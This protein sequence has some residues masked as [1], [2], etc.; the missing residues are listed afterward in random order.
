MI[1]RIHGAGGGGGQSQPKV[2]QP[3]KPVIAQDDAA[4]KSI[5]FAKLQFL[6]CEGDL[7]GPAYG[8]TKQGL[9][10]SVYL[11]DTPI[12]LSSGK[13]SPKPEDLVFS[14]GRPASEQ[15]SVPDYNELVDTIGVNQLCEF[16]KTVT[17][18]VTEFE[19]P[20][21][22]SALVLV[23]FEALQITTIDG[24]EA[25]GNTGDVRTYKVEYKVDYIDA[26][27]TKRTPYNTSVKGKFSSTFQRSHE[28]AL[29]GVGPWTVRVTRLTKDDDSYDPNEEVARSAFNFSSV[30][31][32]FKEAINYE[33]SSVLTVGVRADNYEQIPNISIEL[34]G[35]KVE[36]PKNATVEADGSLS[37]TGTW[38]GTFQTAWTSDP[39]WC[40]RDLILNERYGAGEYIDENFVD[41]WSLYQI[42]QYCNEPVPKSGQSVRLDDYSDF[43]AGS[44]ATI[45]AET[46]EN[47]KVGD[48]V[49]FMEAGGANLDSALSTGTDYVV[50]VQTSTTVQ[51]ELASAP[52]TPITLAGD[53]GTGSANTPAPAAIVMGVVEPRFSCNLLLQSSGEA[54]TVLQQVSSIFRGMVYYASSIAVVA[55]DKEK[56]AIFTFNESN[57]IEEYDDSGQVSQGN[58]TYSGS[59][60][61]A[62]RTVCLVSW[63]DPNN[64]WEPRIECVADSEALKEYGYRSVDLRVLGVTSRSQALRA[65]NWTLLSEQLLT[66]TITFKTNEIGMA[67]RP[68]DI[69]KIA[70]PT[71]AAVRAG[72]RITAVQGDKISLDYLPPNPPGGLIGSKISWMYNLPDAGLDGPNQPRLQESTVIGQF[73]P[74]TSDWENALANCVTAPDPAGDYDI[75][76][77]G[78]IDAGVFVSIC[79]D[80]QDPIFDA[81]TANWDNAD[82]QPRDEIGS[83]GNNTIIIDTDGGHPPEV[84]NPFLLEFP[85]RSAQKFR[86]LTISQEEEGVFAI[87][88]LRYRDDIYDRVD[89]DTPLDEDDD[90]LFKPVNPTE[91]TDVRA[92]VIWDNGQAKI[93]IRWT[94]PTLSS[95]LFQYNLEV[96]NY[97]VQWQS[98]TIEAGEVTW[99]GAWIELPPQTDDREMV[100]IDE[101]SISDKF[102][103]RICSV[104]RLGVQSPW[105]DYVTAEDINV[106]SPMPDISN[107]PDPSVPSTFLTYQN[108][109]TGGQLFTWNFSSV[110]VPKY[111]TGVRLDV[112][113]DT[114]LTPEQAAG[115]K[116][117]DADGYYVY[118]DYPLEEYAVAIFHADT[119]W[120]C[121]IKFLTAVIGLTGDT[122]ASVIVKRCDIVPPSPNL[123][124]VVTET[125]NKSIAPLR[126]FS[127]ELPTSEIV[128]GVGPDP[129]TCGV[130]CLCFW[131]LGKVTDISQFRI[132]YKAGVINNWDLGVPLFADG[133]PG[134]QRYFETELFDGGQWTVM[135]RS[136][137]KTGWVSDDQATIQINI[138][139]AI[140]T[141]VVDTFEAHT[142]GWPGQKTNC[143]VV[144]G[145]LVQTDPTIDA[146]YSYAFEVVTATEDSG[147]VIT[148]KSAGTYQW[149]IREVE[150]SID[151][152]MY[153]DPQGDPM[154]PDPQTDYMYLDTDNT[155]G[156]SYHPYVPFEKLPAGNYEIACVIKSVDGTTPTELE[157]ATLALD[158]PD[159]RQSMEDVAIDNTGNQTVAFPTPFPHKCKAVSITLQD[160]AGAVTVPATAY[161]RGKTVDN[162]TIRL[163][164]AD[165][166]IIEG[167]ADIVAVG[168]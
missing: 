133:V 136:V 47:F 56:D 87:T 6:L 52:G 148:T 166:N 97:R 108:Q 162:F 115:I 19:G 39:A 104:G 95:T 25:K 16:N 49:Q 164:D 5:S 160:P 124:T 98:G 70:D 21:K 2:K 159:V 79:T 35:L 117:P 135:I 138:G 157:E 141:N 121:R 167:L 9:E 67:L 107:D 86:I 20:G 50:T 161:I 125:D 137:D 30:G 163:L 126:R 85:S 146:L 26:I 101:L 106:S 17:Q 119:N 139:D 120:T 36:I 132:R 131:P 168:Y 75:S 18:T 28:F 152:P 153:P 78:T 13:I 83:G 12:R 102:R 91:P 77:A 27:G 118:G 88:G 158:Y 105:S 41:K 151:K 48:T 145:K 73:N 54:W 46:T 37:Y 24:D 40:L 64:N 76:D 143:S 34:K 111:V 122:H 156:T 7:E 89:F 51:V 130:D 129:A 112:K 61:R 59:A 4:L 11:D 94:P 72:G 142:D 45:T 109:S 22:Y 123:F 114:P 96:K 71:K 103:V 65:A 60:R 29:K 127:W 100:P 84:N 140:P 23:T 55:Q 62:R 1:K 57:T 99:S 74:G 90:S 66:D 116:P 31:V 43:P 165:G 38:D 32:A 14:Y 63:D 93:E 33:N 44:P 58:F 10:K 69:V 128:P 92:K 68:G 134:D 3:P 80:P 81:G 110:N 147:P 154:Y 113:P 82:I 53:G 155:L 150:G 8:N 15:S 149:F 144:D 42:S